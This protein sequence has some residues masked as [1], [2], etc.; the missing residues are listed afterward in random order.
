MRPPVDEEPLRIVIFTK[1]R[2]YDLLHLNDVMLI[3]RLILNAEKCQIIFQNNHFNLT[4][5]FHFDDL[6]GKIIAWS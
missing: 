1:K 2:S 3:N 6:V 4:A 5:N